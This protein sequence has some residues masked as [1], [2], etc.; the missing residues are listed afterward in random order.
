MM[1]GLWNNGIES[2]DLLDICEKLGA[3]L[4]EGIE[5]SAED[6]ENRIGMSLTLLAA[7]SKAHLQETQ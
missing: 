5:G 3:N 2:K 4:V 7:L 6:R 1:E